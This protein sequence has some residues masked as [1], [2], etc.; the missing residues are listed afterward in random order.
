M[1]LSQF[2][3]HLFAQATGVL[4]WPPDTALNTPMP[5]IELALGAHARH[6][7][8]QFKGLAALLGVEVGGD[9]DA[10][11]PGAASTMTAAARRRVSRGLK[12]A[13]GARAKKR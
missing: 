9:A 2:C 10:P 11:P 8:A 3:D 1:T 12:A 13:L 6:R 7:R 4:G 5:E